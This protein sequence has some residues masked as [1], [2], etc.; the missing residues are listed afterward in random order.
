VDTNSYFKK[1]TACGFTWERRTDLLAD[2]S[3]RVLGY[4]GHAAELQSGY[5]LF[6]HTCE[7]TFAVQV[8]ELRDLCEGTV[9]MKLLAGGQELFS[10][11]SHKQ[12]LERELVFN[13]LQIIKAWP[14]KKTVSYGLVTESVPE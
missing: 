3:V 5:I 4:Q 2:P 1:C 9:S 7:T 10:D 13:I 8:T 12:L 6:N 14:K 11:R